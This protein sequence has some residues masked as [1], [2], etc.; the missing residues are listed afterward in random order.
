MMSSTD[1]GG[2]PKKQFFYEQMTDGAGTSRGH[3]N[4][5]NSEVSLWGIGGSS[6]QDRPFPPLGV[7]LGVQ[8]PLKQSKKSERRM[9]CLI[10][11]CHHSFF[12]LE[13]EVARAEL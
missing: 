12:G 4:L 9:F 3:S 13:A 7:A 10:P 5:T 11:A 1:L 8:V 2:D 6:L